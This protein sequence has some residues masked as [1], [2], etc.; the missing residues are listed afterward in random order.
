MAKRMTGQDLNNRPRSGAAGSEEGI[1]RPLRRSIDPDV[2]TDVLMAM[3]SKDLD[4]LVR[5][6]GAR[7]VAHSGQGLFG[8]YQIKAGREA[9]G[10]SLCGPFIGAPLAVMGMEKMIA[11]GAKRIWVL[12]WCGSLQPD[13]R[14]GDLVIPETSLS[15]E[16]TSW[17]YPVGDRGPATDRGLNQVLEKAFLK[18]GERVRRGGVWTTDAPYRETPAKVRAFREKGS[19]AVEMEISALITVGTFRGVKV[20]GVLV[21]SDE[22][23]DLR[24]QPGFSSD[25]FKSKSR[26]AAE[27]LVHTMIS[28]AGGYHQV[29]HEDHEEE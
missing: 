10:T 6:Q 12:G 20:S 7:K 16:G 8:L 24:W 5:L 11:L 9:V 13:L 23:F 25:R 22:L 17:H 15:E 27:V 2:G 26:L 14:I 1:I 19:L 4:Y 29:G 28:F 21:V 18:R 3:V